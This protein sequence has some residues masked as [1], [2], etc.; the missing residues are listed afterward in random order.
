[1][2]AASAALAMT[3]DI[4]GPWRVDR[5]VMWRSS[6]LKEPRLPTRIT[7]SRVSNFTLPLGV[8]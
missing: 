7:S 1:L 6:S 5:T 2:G 4:T 8:T 3:S